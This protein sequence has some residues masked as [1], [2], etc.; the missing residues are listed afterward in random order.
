MSFDAKTYRDRWTNWV[1]DPLLQSHGLTFDRTPAGEIS[2]PPGKV[3][4]CGWHVD[5][6]ERPTC[7]IDV[8][9]QE[10]AEFI[11]ANLLEACGRNVDFAT[12][13]DDSGA[14]LVKAPY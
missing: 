1:N 13:H 5:I 10:E 11:C 8:A 3:R 4:V 9:S 7:W 12:A 6:D 2:A 14:T